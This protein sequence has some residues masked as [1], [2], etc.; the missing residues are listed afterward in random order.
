MISTWGCFS[1][2]GFTNKDKQEM[3]FKHPCTH[4][5]DVHPRHTDPSKL[6]E[7]QKAIHK[8]VIQTEVNYFN[9][10]SLK[11]SQM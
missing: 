4:P 7:S 1:K 10:V 9:K 3:K 2:R 6:N 8:S 11:H 5:S